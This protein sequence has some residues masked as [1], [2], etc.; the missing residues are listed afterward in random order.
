MPLMGHPSHLFLRFLPLVILLVFFLIRIRK[1]ISQ[2]MNNR[3][4][5]WRS[6]IILFIILNVFFLTGKNWLAK[7]GI[8]SEVLLMGNL[9]LGVATALAF[10]ISFKS[11]ASANPNASI[12]AMYGSF[13][14]KFFI[15]IIAAF[16]Y[17]IFAKKNVNKPALFICMGLYI[18][19]T[20]IEVSTLTKVLKEKKNA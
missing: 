4:K 18:I 17:I 19:Y 9:V 7:Q 15:C 20:F 3:I 11:L 14:V 6:I 10:W 13:M 12:R 2:N 1:Q 5:H 8:D 16:V